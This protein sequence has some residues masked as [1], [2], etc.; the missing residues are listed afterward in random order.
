MLLKNSLRLNNFVCKHDRENRLT[1][2][3]PL[4]LRINW[5]TTGLTSRH[6]LLA[7]ETNLFKLEECLEFT[8]DDL[9]RYS[10]MQAPCEDEAT[11]IGQMDGE[12]VVT[13]AKLSTDVECFTLKELKQLH[14]R[15][16]VAMEAGMTNNLHI[17]MRIMKLL[18]KHVVVDSEEQ[19]LR[20]LDVARKEVM[21]SYK[22]ALE[23][24]SRSHDMLREAKKEKLRAEE[25]YVEAV[26]GLNKAEQEKNR[27]LSVIKAQ[28][29]N[30]G[31]RR[32][33]SW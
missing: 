32:T 30:G 24:C 12:A 6:A 4:F 25:E 23:R 22:T 15:S 18:E 3:T 28:P 16:R 2:S 10:Q 11:F 31:R 26:L 27:V 17:H 33:T 9:D 8:T 13:L 29:M 21:C 19:K 5:E 7:S 14:R 20:R 1:F